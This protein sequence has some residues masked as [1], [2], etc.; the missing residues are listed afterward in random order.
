MRRLLLRAVVALPGPLRRKVLTSAFRH[1]ED[2]FNRGDLDAV[3]ASFAADVDYVPPSRLPGAA[4]IRGKAAVLAFWEAIAAR[5]ES[6]IETSE[7]REAGRGRMLRL[8]SLRHADRGGG[9]ALALEY[10]IEQVTEISG[11]EVVRQ[12]NTVLG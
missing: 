11:G 1:A 12:H 3:F 2:A 10:E 4:P 6:T 9:D 8:A 7:L 5:Y